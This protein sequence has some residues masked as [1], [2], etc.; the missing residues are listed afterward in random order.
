MRHGPEASA[1]IS[2]STVESVPAPLSGSTSP[3]NTTRTISSPSS[4]PSPN[5]RSVRPPH[6]FR[7][8]EASTSQRPPW[9]TMPLAPT[10]Q[11]REQRDVLVVARVGEPR[12]RTAVRTACSSANSRS[13][14]PRRRG[15]FGVRRAVD[16]THLRG[17]A[18]RGKVVVLDAPR[19]K[20]CDSRAPGA[21]PTRTSRS[22][23]ADRALVW[24]P[25]RRRSGRRSDSS[26]DW[27][28]VVRASATVASPPTGLGRNPRG[29]RLRRREFALGAAR[30]E[31]A[32][33]HATT[34]GERGA[35]H[36]AASATLTD[37]SPCVPR[38]DLSLTSPSGLGNMDSRMRSRTS[39]GRGSG[40]VA[41]DDD[42]TASE[43]VS[44]GY[45]PRMSD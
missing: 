29:V 16:V 37:G 42:A 45:K 7:V 19:K 18:N 30:I 3:L 28:R 27:T 11:H 34:G 20:G 1:S 38:L 25:R 6:R 44:A 21:V 43:S 26:R 10:R 40:D 13:G 31:V 22:E 8:R 24:T 41:R 15:A 9:T 12:R 5:A 33:V 23:V 32:S 39:M 36:A 17:A 35:F 14:D 2:P 4:S